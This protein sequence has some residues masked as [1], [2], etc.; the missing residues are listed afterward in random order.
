MGGSPVHQ[1]VLAGAASA[2]FTHFE[3]LLEWS[4]KVFFL[5]ERFLSYEN[6]DDAASANRWLF[7]T[8]ENQE[9]RYPVRSCRDQGM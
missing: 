8:S 4:G 7:A 5:L 3:D 9:V 6:L 1:S 2:R